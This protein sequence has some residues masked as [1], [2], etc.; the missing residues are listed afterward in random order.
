[1]NTFKIL[2][3]AL[4]V[5]PSAA[6]QNSARFVIGQ[7]DR[8]G[9][10]GGNAMELGIQCNVGEGVDRRFS[11]YAL[12]SVTGAGTTGFWGAWDGQIR[13]S[14]GRSGQP[15]SVDAM[16][17]GSEDINLYLVWLD[18]PGSVIRNIGWSP[19]MTLEVNV[20]LL[21]SNGNASGPTTSEVFNV[22]SA[23]WCNFSRICGEEQYGCGPA[24]IRDS[25]VN[26]MQV[27]LYRYY[28]AA[29]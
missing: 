19:T 27:L 5:L 3:A 21:D 11:T 22:D 8:S 4:L 17:P 26:E 20:E 14:Y 25:I 24:S 6:A 12:Q 13:I 28:S 7:I 2:A 18:D 15:P 10:G 29:E 23:A 1:M 16:K 9:T